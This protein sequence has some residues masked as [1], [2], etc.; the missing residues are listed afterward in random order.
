MERRRRR[1]R[2]A[3]ADGFG[4]GGAATAWAAAALSARACRLPSLCAA[5]ERSGAQGSVAARGNA[6]AVTAAAAAA[7]RAGGRVRTGRS[8]DRLGGRCSVCHEHAVCAARA[9][10]GAG[11]RGG[12]GKRDC[13]CRGAAVM[14]R[15]GRTTSARRTGRSSSASRAVTVSVARVQP[16]SGGLKICFG[17]QRLDNVGASVFVA[18]HEQEPKKHPFPGLSHSL[19]VVVAPRYVARVQPGSG[20]LKHMKVKQSSFEPGTSGA[21]RIACV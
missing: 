8:S 5:R 21:C 10:S 6:A 14:W 13:R 7:A 2:H 19:N 1:Q 17:T 18:I 11:K 4:R 12:A 9:R 3:R 16:G 15:G 20:G